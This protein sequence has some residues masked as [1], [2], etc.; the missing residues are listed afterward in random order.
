MVWTRA[1]EAAG[2]PDKKSYDLRSTWQATI[3]VTA[4]LLAN[5]GSVVMFLTILAYFYLHRDED[6]GSWSQ[7]LF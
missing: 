6:S 3:K 7:S 5:T 2:T 1:K 4:M